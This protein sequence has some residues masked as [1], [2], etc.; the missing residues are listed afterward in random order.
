MKAII[1]TF[2]FCFSVHLFSFEII[3]KD[4]FGNPVIPTY[5]QSVHKY[6]V[7]FNKIEATDKVIIFANYYYPRVINKP[8]GKEK[9]EVFLKQRKRININV[10]NVNCITVVIRHR[11]AKNH[12]EKYIISKPFYIPDF[13]KEETVYIYSEGFYPIVL[14]NPPNF[15]QVLKFKKA[16]YYCNIQ[17]EKEM[18]KKSLFEN[19]I[20]PDGYFAF[21]SN[22]VLKVKDFA[23]LSAKELPKNG[24][25]VKLEREAPV[26]F[27][28]SSDISIKISHNRN[29]LKSNLFSVKDGV[30]HGL[31]EGV[32]SFVVFK[33]KV[34]CNVYKNITITNSGYNLGNM[35]CNTVLLKVFVVDEGENSV[36]GCK[37]T[38]IG[39]L[40][41]LKETDKS[42]KATFELKKG[43]K[44]KFS[45]RKQGFA[46]YYSEVFF[47]ESDREYKVVL[48]KGGTVYLEYSEPE[49]S[50]KIGCFGKN[51]REAV[52]FEKQND[53]F[54]AKN[55]SDDI[56][57]INFTDY[58]THFAKKLKLEV[59]DGGE[60]Y[61][62][63]EEGLTSVSGYVK[64]EL[65]KD[66]NWS[67]R[68][69]NDNNTVRVE[70]NKDNSFFIKNIEYG[71]YT[72]FLI[73][74]KGILVGVLKNIVI[75][76]TINDLIL[77]FKALKEIRE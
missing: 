13:L 53:L 27:E 46:K 51:H 42:G 59:T 69:R 35:V 32:Y 36:S 61:V 73:N 62:N 1:L 63:I 76:E 74:E 30:I 64:P 8:Q 24:E 11:N 22:S 58:N 5:I 56:Y 29:Y 45:V 43:T 7:N 54:V 21:E 2:V 67:L 57:Y 38:V 16:R 39:G 77:D 3:V 26:F 33:G 6:S 70:V 19:N 55:L 18:D 40:R 47:I 65:D 49:N 31:K 4:Q 72:V 60:Y 75:D 17:I 15:K 23:Y 10:E 66:K 37:V 71:T 12:Y 28:K 25:T 50:I 14:F 48:S 34:V 9:V 52:K 44:V 20:V 68:F 41:Y